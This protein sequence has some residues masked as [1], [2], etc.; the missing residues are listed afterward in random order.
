MFKFSNTEQD[1]AASRATQ[2]PSS[3][4]TITTGSYPML[5]ELLVSATFLSLFVRYLHKSNV[6]RKQYPPG[7]RGLPIIGNLYDLPAAHPWLVF[8]QWCKQYN[9]DI[10]H[11]RVLGQSVMILNSKNAVSEILE[12]RSSIHSDRP[13]T[14]MLHD[15][16]GL[17]TWQGPSFDDAR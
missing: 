10:V 7:P 16:M 12:K 15:V 4:L 5:L 6:T 8:E 1:V 9:S 3:S 14:A 11:A 13:D 17:G 2:A